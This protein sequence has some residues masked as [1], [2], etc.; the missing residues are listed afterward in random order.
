MLS[1][2]LGSAATSLMVYLFH[3]TEKLAKMT[4][5]YSYKLRIFWRIQ[6]NCS[7]AQATDKVVAD[8]V[9]ALKLFAN[10]ATYT[11]ENGTWWISGTTSQSRH[12]GNGLAMIHYA[13]FE[14]MR[15]LCY[16][17]FVSGASND[18]W[19]DLQFTASKGFTIAGITY[20]NAT[21]TGSD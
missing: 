3:L 5:D 19:F 10:I 17:F 8:I 9:G 16:G 6:T 13:A 20:I 11:D 14:H 15:K 21:V 1:R 18:V 2:L 4:I 12:D 7:N